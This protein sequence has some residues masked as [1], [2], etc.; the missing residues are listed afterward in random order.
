MAQ[1]VYAPAAV[2]DLERVEEFLS[3]RGAAGQDALDAILAGIAVLRSHP[4]IGRPAEHGLHELVLS[5]GRTGYV[6]LY[7]FLEEAELIV[8]LGIRHQR[9]LAGE[10]E[11][12]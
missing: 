1:V 2:E 10:G 5:R 7:T 11:V 12:P 9:E 3:S 8:V 4:L 6:A